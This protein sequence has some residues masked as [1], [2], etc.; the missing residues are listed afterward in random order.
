MAEESYQH[1]EEFDD[2]AECAT[3]VDT[4]AAA[5][6]MHCRLGRRGWQGGTYVIG[7]PSAVVTL[8][9]QSFPSLCTSCGQNHHK[10]IVQRIMVRTPRQ[11]HGTQ[12]MRELL[13]ALPEHMGLYLQSTVTVGGQSLARH[14][15]M[16][17]HSYDKNQ[18]DLCRHPQCQ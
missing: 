10:L 3:D 8:Q 17:Q 9:T 1:V 12:V 5:A 18:W 13:G 14:L 6:A 7:H 4:A 2:A 15:G 11:G 16:T